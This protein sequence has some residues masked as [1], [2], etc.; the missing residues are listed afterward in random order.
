MYEEDEDS[1]DT[2]TTP[3]PSTS[4]PHPESQPLVPFPHAGSSHYGSTDHHRDSKPFKTTLIS[5]LFPRSKPAA[6]AESLPVMPVE[7]VTE[8]EA[9]GNMNGTPNGH[10][11]D[12]KSTQETHNNDPSNSNE[13]EYLKSKLWYIFP[14]A[15]GTQTD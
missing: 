9:L 11:K 1:D 13:S 5:R 2:A 15:H 7:V 14:Y 10:K 3:R 8:Q 6:S 4:R 12:A